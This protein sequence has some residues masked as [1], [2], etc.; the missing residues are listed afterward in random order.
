M[1]SSNVNEDVVYDDNLT[2]RLNKKLGESS[3]VWQY[4]GKLLRDGIEID[5]T[6]NYCDVCLTSKV[7]KR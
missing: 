1:G 2:V 3:N 6:H 7:I 4:Y 5:G